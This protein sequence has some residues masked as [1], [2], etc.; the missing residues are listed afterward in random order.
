[1]GPHYLDN[2]LLCGKLYPDLTGEFHV[3]LVLLFMILAEAV[4]L[5]DVLIHLILPSIFDS[6]EVAK[7]SFWE[8]QGL[9]DNFIIDPPDF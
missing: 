4:F 2:Y 8:E 1:V 6:H 9:E 7:Q 5:V 3:P